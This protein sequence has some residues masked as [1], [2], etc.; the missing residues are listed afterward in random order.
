MAT[1]VTHVCMPY[2]SQDLQVKVLSCLSASTQRQALNN[3]A[4]NEVKLPDST[5]TYVDSAL[6]LHQLTVPGAS[7]LKSRHSS[8]CSQIHQLHV[9]HMALRTWHLV[10]PM[11][12][13]LM[14]MQ[15]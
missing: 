11:C 12:R 2:G 4:F 3:G 7:P 1:V 14:Q 10:W 9:H 5:D 15:V 13:K 8:V 6:V